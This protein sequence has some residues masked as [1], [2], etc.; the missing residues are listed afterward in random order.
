MQACVI[1]I[2]VTSITEKHDADED[3]V[4]YDKA[5]ANDDDT[6]DSASALNT[7]ANDDDTNDS[8][9]A[10][11]TTSGDGISVRSINTHQ[12]ACLTTPF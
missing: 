5:D 10:L 8:A 12:I 4:D 11:N 6:N 2:E 7:D 3:D 1:M 9:S